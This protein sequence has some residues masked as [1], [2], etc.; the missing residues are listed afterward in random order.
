LSTTQ[1]CDTVRIAIAEGHRLVGDAFSAMCDLEEDFEVVGVATSGSDAV[2]L[3]VETCPDVV[4]MASEL[5]GLNGIEATRRIVER[6]SGTRVLL[7]TMSGDEQM[8][9][10][11]IAAGAGG[12]VSKNA[13]SRVLF[14]AVRALAGGGA[15]I[16][17]QLACG[18]LQRIAPLVNESLVG[19]RLT[20]K[21]SEILQELAIG[22]AAKEI[23]QRLFISEETV[24][25]HLSRIYRK[26]GVD[27]RV[28]AVVIAI[29]RGLVP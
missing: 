27:D 19:E 22:L 24:K 11:A 9:A 5:V 2:A 23:A 26:L 25:T 16:D 14:D 8:V 28:K 1:S 15:F 4:V 3:V 17:P 6:G 29:R 12:L 18:L 20:A 21:E 10:Q 13:E 7:L